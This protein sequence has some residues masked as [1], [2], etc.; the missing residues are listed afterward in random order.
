MQKLYQEDCN[1]GGVL[2]YDGNNFTHFT[3][4]EGL[5]TNFVLS[6]LEDKSGNLYEKFNSLSIFEEM[7]VVAMYD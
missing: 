6:S 4:K 2:K 5:S 7:K 1:G 3:D